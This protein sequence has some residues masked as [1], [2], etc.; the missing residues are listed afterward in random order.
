MAARPDIRRRPARRGAESLL[1]G[2]G[3]PSVDL[4]DDHL[5]HFFFC[6]APDAPTGLVGLELYGDAA[7]LRSL[8]VAP[9][10]RS[11]G[12]GSALVTHAEAHARS[13]SVRGRYLLTTTAES[14]FAQRGYA[15]VDRGRAPPAIRAT[16]EFGE[17]CPS[18]SAFMFKSLE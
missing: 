15:R 14:F 7:L 13:Q 10:A 3:L 2:A 8:A 17:L 6:G 18:H 4:T 16:R 12:L 11:A 1:S 5:D 9:G